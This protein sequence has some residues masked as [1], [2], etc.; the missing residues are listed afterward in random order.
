M[1]SHLLFTSFDFDEGR[2]IRVKA[3]SPGV[4]PTPAHENAS[5]SRD[6]LNSF[7]TLSAPAR[8][9]RA[10][11]GVCNAA[12]SLAFF[13]VD[14]SKTL[15]RGRAFQR[16][17]LLSGLRQIQR[18]ARLRNVPT[19]FANMSRQSELANN[20]EQAQRC[21]QSAFIWRLSA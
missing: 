7:E 3:I 13:I 16:A 6:A 5:A 17:P 4:I 19:L 9:Q 20:H 2:G 11:F 15:I 14:K 8:A 10:A 1:T 21:L 12:P 18:S